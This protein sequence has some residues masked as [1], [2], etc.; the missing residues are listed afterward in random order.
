V[1]RKQGHF[2]VSTDEKCIAYKIRRLNGDSK[3]TSQL[4]FFALLSWQVLFSAQNRHRK[5]SALVK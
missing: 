4:Q 5:I 3:Y 1:S 2:N